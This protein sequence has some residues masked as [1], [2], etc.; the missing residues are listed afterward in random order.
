MQNFSGTTSS[1]LIGKNSQAA[2]P[3]GR[4]PPKSATIVPPTRMPFV[5]SKPATPSVSE[6][7]ARW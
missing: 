7:R 5:S 2:Q 3:C 4:A 6:S 1:R